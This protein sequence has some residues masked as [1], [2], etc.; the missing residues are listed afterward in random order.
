M[1]G[2]G[3][4]VILQSSDAASCVCSATSICY[5]NPEGESP[6]GIKQ[7]VTKNAE[8]LQISQWRKISNH[9]WIKFVFFRLDPSS[10]IIKKHS[11]HSS[12]LLF[13]SPEGLHILNK[14]GTTE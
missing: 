11:Q 12:P 10:I 8:D 1:F 5:L 7:K 3:I 9:Q 2:F 13:L 6:F 14:G 4:S